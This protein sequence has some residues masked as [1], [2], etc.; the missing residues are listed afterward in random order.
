MCFNLKNVEPTDDN[1]KWSARQA[2]VWHSFDLGAGLSKW[3]VVKGNDL[4]RKRIASVR[5]S[6]PLSE[7]DPSKRRNQVFGWCLM[8]HS[9]ICEWSG[10]GWRAYIN[11]LEN[12]FN[13]TSRSIVSEQIRRLPEPVAEKPTTAA[14][15]V[16][17][18][19]PRILGRRFRNAQRRTMQTLPLPATAMNRSGS[20][21]RGRN[22]LGPPEMPP[23]LPPH[24]IAEKQMASQTDK[25]GGFTFS[26][27]QS[28]HFSEERVSDSL[29][30][31]KGNLDVLESLKLYYTTL[32][33]ANDIPQ[34]LQKGCE[35]ELTTFDERVTAVK[36]EL[37]MNVARAERLLQIIEA[38]KS[39]VS[40]HWGIQIRFVLTKTV[41]RTSRISRHGSQ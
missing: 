31:T 29:L 14:N 40:N 37:S 22:L 35:D 11:H 21:D 2:L 8:L 18:P 6:M 1:L 30:M 5:D 32:W 9:L 17:R 36:K 20:H 27:L 10:E 16:I 38:R 7:T 13:Q 33:K 23:E 24:I 26:N 39:L 25:R 28:L 15:P 3:L 4:I 12:E 19:R 34:E 41:F